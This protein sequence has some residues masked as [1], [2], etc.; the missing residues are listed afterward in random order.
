MI[1]L[2]GIKHSVWVGFILFVGIE[3]F[4]KGLMGEAESDQVGWSPICFYYIIF[5]SALCRDFYLEFVRMREGG[6]VGV[7][8][9]P[10]VVGGFFKVIPGVAQRMKNVILIVCCLYCPRRSMVVDINVF[11][12]GAS[13][14]LAAVLPLQ[15]PLPPPPRP[16]K[17]IEHLIL[18]RVCINL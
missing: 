2:A 1:E 9:R 13:F 4:V 14:A 18:T 3:L 12:V 6:R 11:V 7:F 15:L 17:N 5:S 16:P 8:T 10:L